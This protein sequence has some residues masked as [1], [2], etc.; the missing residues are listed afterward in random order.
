MGNNS[1][2]ISLD[3]F[4]ISHES[5]LFLPKRNKLPLPAGEGW[6]EVEADEETN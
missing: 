1:P 2:A 6:G 5:I 4:A 3:Y